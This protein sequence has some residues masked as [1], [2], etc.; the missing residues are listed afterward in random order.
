[1]SGRGIIAAEIF[2]AEQLSLA[3]RGT[4]NIPGSD[5]NDP[6]VGEMWPRTDLSPSV[7]NATTF[8][9]MRVQ[10]PTGTLDWPIIDIDD[11]SKLGPDVYIG[12]TLKI[13][14]PGANPGGT[15]PSKTGFLPVTDQG[16]S[17]G[18]P[19]LLHNGVEYQAHD[20][21]DVSAI[22][23]AGVNHRHPIQSGEETTAEDTFGDADLS[24]NGATLVSGSDFIEGHAWELD[25]SDTPTAPNRS[26]MSG[27]SDGMTALITINP[28][29]ISTTQSIQTVYETGVDDR[30]WYYR[31]TDTSTELVL[32]LSSNGSNFES[33]FYSNIGLAAD[34]LQRVG[35]RWQS[36]SVPEIIHNGTATS[37]D[38]NTTTLSQIYQT[39]ANY[40]VGHREGSDQFTGVIDSP[41]IVGEYWD[42]ETIQQ[43]YNTMPFA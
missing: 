9:V 37:P 6:A 38:S 3:K 39:A 33:Y 5:P 36:D 29:T 42:D 24:A 8:G 21:L 35:F 2:R 13:A 25:G 43:D 17:L 30:A 26:T 23:D 11:A 40:D 4:T 28:S 14:E 15:Q 1:M 22:P 7:S 19:R 31:T 41:Q 18:S 32:T 27:F 16:G 20:A 10:G 34:T 12:A